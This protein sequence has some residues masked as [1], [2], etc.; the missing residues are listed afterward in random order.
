[1]SSK[2]SKLINSNIKATNHVSR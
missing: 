2:P 1:M